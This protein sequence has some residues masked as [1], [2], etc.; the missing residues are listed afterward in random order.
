MLIDDKNL[1]RK[2][3]IHLICSYIVAV[4]KNNTKL[5]DGRLKENALLIFHLPS[6]LWPTSL[7]NNS[8]EH[9]NEDNFA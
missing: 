9:E 2:K 5:C 7:I 4:N 8:N 1:H 3:I 6:F